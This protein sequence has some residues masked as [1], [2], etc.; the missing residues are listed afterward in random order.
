MNDPTDFPGFFHESGI[1]ASVKYEAAESD[2]GFTGMFKGSDHGVLRLSPLAPLTAEL[3]LTHFFIGTY[4]FSSALKLFRDGM[5]SGNSLTGDTVKA[6]TEF[7]NSRNFFDPPNFNIFS[8]PLDNLSGI[9]DSLDKAFGEFEHV[10]G[11]VSL[12]DLAA[13]DQDGNEEASPKTPL[14]TQLRPNPYLHEKFGV[15]PS[16]EFREWATA[17]GAV[18]ADTMIYSVWTT[19]YADSGEPSLCVDEAGVPQVD[20]NVQKLCPDQTVIKMGDI[21]ST[22]RFYAAEWPDKWLFFQHTRACPKD[23][24]LC[25]LDEVND[26]SVR[27]FLPPEP[28][29]FS[30]SESSGTEYACVSSDDVSGEVT[31]VLPQCPPEWTLSN[32]SCFPGQRRKVEEIQTSQCPMFTSRLSPSI[33]GVDPDAEPSEDPSCS[34]TENFSLKLLEIALFAFVSPIRFLFSILRW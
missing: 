27:P 30:S 34:L 10:S 20:E 8:R 29:F 16:L 7:R 3:Y 22:S 28:T 1:I 31:G 19:V 14:I 17:E 26:E 5:H 23:Q 15:G 9:G 2:H 13:Y 4:L 24:A 32:D 11:L 12:S 33:L 18:P 21:T 6:Y 25:E